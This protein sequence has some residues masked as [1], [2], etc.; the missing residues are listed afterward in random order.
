MKR[1]FPLL[2]VLVL[3]CG[4]TP[5]SRYDPNRHHYVSEER[6]ESPA[7]WYGS[8]EDAFPPPDDFMMSNAVASDAILIGTVKTDGV[9]IDDPLSEKT[10]EL[11]QRYTSYT[12][13]VNEIWFGD[14]QQDELDVWI[15]GDET[16][17]RLPK[18]QKGDVL[19]LFL[20]KDLHQDVYY[21]SLN[22][23]CNTFAINP[24]DDT[25]FSFCSHEEMTSFDGKSV[26]TLKKAIEKKLKEFGKVEED[27]VYWCGAVGK[28]Y[29][30][31]ALT[32]WLNGD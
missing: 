16:F 2:L 24:P 4:C 29:R 7:V 30:S 9:I 26:N 18:P 17:G 31:Q 23:D 32:D 14:T 28:E 1:L 22:Y 8:D 3:L 27:Y 11:T 6:K 5:K 13:E 12:V 21:Q 25:L 19:I 20:R 10:P 15:V